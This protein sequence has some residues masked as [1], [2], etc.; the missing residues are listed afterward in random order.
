MRITAILAYSVT[1]LVELTTRLLPP[2][3]LLAV[4][5][6]ATVIDSE[7]QSRVYEDKKNGYFKFVPPAGWRQVDFPTDPRTKVEFKS[8]DG[9]LMR[10]IVR[11]T[12]SE[13]R[14]L[15]RSYASFM[16]ER[17]DLTA[18]MRAHPNSREISSP[19]ETKIAGFPANRQRAILRD[20]THMEMIHFYGG[21]LFCNF[22]VT[23]R[24]QG[25]LES[26]LPVAMRSLETT[27][28][29]RGSKPGEAERQLVA[30]AVR[31]GHLLAKQ[32]NFASAEA[33]LRD[34]LEMS[35]TDTQL[36]ESLELVLKKQVPPEVHGRQ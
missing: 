27:V 2:L 23:A 11:G 18:E 8:D 35:P 13:D 7:A 36:R 26:V 3:V 29:L 15:M 30:R 17:R 12:D 19:Q 21:T 22:A 24:S 1:L 25:Q 5:L 14:E 32:G 20:G 16:N 33:T 9:A 4:G 10:L 6:L 28:I 31:L 34:A